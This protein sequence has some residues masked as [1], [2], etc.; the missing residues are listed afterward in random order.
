M[1][2]VVA[3]PHGHRPNAR[4]VLLAVAMEET[5][6]LLLFC[7]ARASGSCLVPCLKCRGS[8]Q[9]VPKDPT[10][11]YGPWMQV[12][13]RRRRPGIAV[14]FQNRDTRA[15]PRM[16]PGGS[17]FAV[18]EEEGDVLGAGADCLVRTEEQV[19]GA[20]RT[21]SSPKVGVESRNTGSSDGVT[22]TQRNER[23][24]GVISEGA[25]VV[26]G[27][28][29]VAEQGVVLPVKSALGSNKHAA[30]QVFGAGEE[31][32]LYHLAATPPPLPH[33]GADVPGWRWDDKREFRVS[34]AY[35]VLMQD[36][37]RVHSSKWA[38]IWSLKVP[39]RVKVFLWITVHH[40][41]LTNVERVRRHIASSDMCGLCFRGP[42][43]ID[44]VLRHCEKANELWR[45]VLGHEVAASLSSL[46]FEDW[47]H[48]NISGSLP[49][50]IGRTDWDM[51]F[52]IYC[53]LLWKLRCSM[54]LDLSFVERESVW[55]R[56]RRLLVECQAV[57]AA[58]VRGPAAGSSAETRW[59][60]LQGNRFAAPPASVALAV[61]ADKQHWEDGSME[62]EVA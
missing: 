43:D 50:I 22:V 9:P 60:S 38:R 29:P 35:S 10:E 58:S 49:A 47:L 15:G 6:K 61:A 1:T 37:A 56:G 2:V 24:V 26:R 16:A 41:L 25:P 53:W 45:N 52:A 3:A 11:P 39:Q 27:P 44:H 48:G 51:E 13:N 5:T 19:V 17:H 34:F 12:M 21:P 4:G 28:A 18:L 40:R 7:L 14:P 59:A 31:V 46:S 23:D 54:V 62:L 8:D 32:I 55:D 30:I 20:E 57:F 33:L 42:E 36:G